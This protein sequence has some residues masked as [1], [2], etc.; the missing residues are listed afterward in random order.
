MKKDLCACVDASF[1]G[2]SEVISLF[3]PFLASLLL[4]PALLNAKED[5]ARRQNEKHE[6]AVQTLKDVGKASGDR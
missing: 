5:V 4:S 1:S 3:L 2:V 6:A